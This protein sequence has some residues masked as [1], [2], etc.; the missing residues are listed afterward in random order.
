[1]QSL[2]YVRVRTQG[3]SKLYGCML[4]GLWFMV[5]AFL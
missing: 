2:K 3:E 4:Y 5:I 1:M